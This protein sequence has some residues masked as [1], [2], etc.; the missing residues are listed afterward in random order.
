MSKKRKEI[1]PEGNDDIDGSPESQ[2]GG[3]RTVVQGQAGGG[4]G[5][6]VIDMILCCPLYC[7]GHP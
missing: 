4:R 7:R 5:G 3:E 2:C 6:V 1:I